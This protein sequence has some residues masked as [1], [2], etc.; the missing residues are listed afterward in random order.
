M[1]F[2][3]TACPAEKAA[4]PHPKWRA[5]IEDE[6]AELNGKIG[7]GL[8]F[9]GFMRH[10]QKRI[11]VALG[12]Y[13]YRVHRGIERYALEHRWHLSTGLERDHVIPWGWR[14]DGILAWLSVDDELAEFVV[15]AKKPTVDFSFRRPQLKFPRVLEDNA[16]AAQLVADHFLARGFRHFVFYSRT[17]NWSYEE[18]GQGFRDAL[19]RAGRDCLWLRWYRSPRFRPGRE[20]LETR[21]AW[22]AAELKRAP[23]PLAVFAANDEHALEVLDVCDDARLAVP[24]EVAIV[25]AENYLLAPDALHT[26]ISSVDTNLELLGYRGAQLLDDLLHGRPAPKNPLRVPA[27]GL[28]VRKSSDILAVNHKGVAASL[29]FM[30]E[31]IHEPITVEDLVRVAAMSR[32]ALHKAFLDYL[33]RTPGQELQRLRIERAKQLLASTSHKLEIIGN[34]CGY[35]GANSFCV[36]FARL[37]GM[38]PNEFRKSVIR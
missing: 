1:L 13:D 31:H 9:I 15:K 10:S 7:A 37:T 3:E 18:R 17:G 4:L 14:G 29:R 28:V 22:L 24:E 38:T 36:A 8:W 32:R 35:E 11:L 30:L 16:H 19:K 20:Q 27:A 2:P 25:G 5:Q 33:H 12:W 21:R 23:K 34:L 6:K 26:P